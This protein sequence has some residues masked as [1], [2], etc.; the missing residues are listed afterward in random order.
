MILD[1]KQLEEAK[2]KAIWMNEHAKLKLIENLFDTLADYRAKYQ[3]T[4][5]Y[6]KNGRQS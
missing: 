4:E 3:A 1:N 5:E 6:V 2:K